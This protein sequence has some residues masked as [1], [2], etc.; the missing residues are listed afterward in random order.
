MQ[1][2]DQY[3]RSVDDLNAEVA[4]LQEELHKSRREHK[5]ALSQVAEMRKTLETMRLEVK[6]QVDGSTS[7]F[8]PPSAVNFR[9]NKLC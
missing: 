7:L 2:K 3:A 5:M 6:R 9:Y 4:S 1:I 8:L